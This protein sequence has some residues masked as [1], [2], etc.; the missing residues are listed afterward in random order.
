R[1]GL[2]IGVRPRGK[3]WSRRWPRVEVCTSARAATIAGSRGWAAGRCTNTGGSS[4]EGDEAY[5]THALR[6]PN[7]V[8]PDQPG[9]G[10]GLADSATRAGRTGQSVGIGTRLDHARR[11]RWGR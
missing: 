8:R 4:P 11:A 10:A 9:F 6:M 1:T 5:V 3:P 2:L 7:T